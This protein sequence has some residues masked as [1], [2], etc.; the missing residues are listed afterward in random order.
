VVP[1]LGV[2]ACMWLAWY[3]VE[4]ELRWWFGKYLLGAVAVYFA[5]GFWVSPMRNK[6]PE[7]PTT[8]AS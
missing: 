6:A 7:T 1:A 8:P 4:P 5:Y 2:L 3:G